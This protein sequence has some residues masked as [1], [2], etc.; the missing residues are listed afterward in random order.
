MKDAVF[1][2]GHVQFW[3]PVGPQVEMTTKQL[4]APGG[5][6]SGGMA[7]RYRDLQ[8]QGQLKQRSGHSHWG[9]RRCEK[10]EGWTTEGA[11]T[12]RGGRRR[13]AQGTGEAVGVFQRRKCQ[14]R[15]SGR[16]GTG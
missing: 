13:P 4:D 3:V 8:T 14:D 15:L 9:P 10:A 5:A 7:W 16:K 12:W 11:V 6:W 1:Q 2:L